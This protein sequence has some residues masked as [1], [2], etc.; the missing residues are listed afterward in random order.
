MTATVVR[1]LH[2]RILPFT[3]SLRVLSLTTAPSLAVFLQTPVA[4]A[5]TVQEVIA[6][7]IPVQDFLAATNDA[8]AEAGVA[9]LVVSTEL[10]TAAAAKLIDMQQSGYWD[11]YRPSDHKAPWD[12]MKEA[13]YS[14]KVAGENLARGFKTVQGITTAWL[15]SPTHRANLLSPKYT[16]VGFA[17]AQVTQPDGSTLLYTVQMF[18]TR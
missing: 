14:Y 7:V 17:D 1:E 6:R 4:H 5:V 3:L 13:G 18:G 9:P 15:N 8:R 12:F 11:H 16:E 10:N 2:R